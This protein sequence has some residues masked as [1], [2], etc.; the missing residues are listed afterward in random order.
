MNLLK[1]RLLFWL[2]ITMALGLC[3]WVGFELSI[4]MTY[5]AVATVCVLAAPNSGAVF[6]KSK[7]RFVGTIAGG[8][9]FV[10]MA[11]F[12]VQA[13]WLF[14][15]GL[16]LWT[17]LCYVVSVYYRFFQA[18]AAA[19]AGYTASILLGSTTDL[20]SVVV[21][22]IDRV[23]EV[24]LGVACIAVVFGIGHIRRGIVR[25]EPEL[26]AQ[27]TRILEMTESILKTPTTANQISLLRLWVSETS[28]LQLSL[29]LLAEEEADYAKQSRSIEL[30][31]LDIFTPLS[32]FAES[33]LALGQAT[34]SP[35]ISKAR[36]SV[37]DCLRF[38]S[39]NKT[40][41]AVQ[42]MIKRNVEN[43]QKPLDD[44]L[45]QIHDLHQREQVMYILV[46]LSRLL[47]ALMIY[48]KARNDVSTYPNRI[49]GQ[50]VNRKI[51]FFDA[52]GVFL[53]YLFFS[54]FWVQSQWP[55]GT[56]AIIIFASILLLQLN[57][58]RPV[59]GTIS[60]IWGFLLASFVVLIIKFTLLPLSGDFT[61]LILCTALALIPGCWFKVDSKTVAIGGGYFLFFSMLMRYSNEM[62][63]DFADFVNTALA[64]IIGLL[65]AIALMAIIHPW[66]GETRLNALCLG[67]FYD[68]EKT[69]TQ[70]L[71]GNDS[72]STLWNDRQFL[73]VRELAHIIMLR[74]PEQ[75]NHA[76][77]RFVQMS[78]LVRRFEYALKETRES[79]ASGNSSD[80]SE[81]PDL[82]S[83][84]APHNTDDLVYAFGL[85]A[86]SLAIAMTQHNQ[87]EQARTWQSLSHDLTRLN[88]NIYA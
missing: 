38:L 49:V 58:D 29:F 40:P 5:S 85:R 68:F 27:A 32:Q 64:C 57:T 74:N 2:Q 13:P 82:L 56:D 76:C 83:P 33:M 24:A 55:Y 80:S 53:G 36:E 4:D 26:K 59:L 62:S 84:I 52:V 51:V 69:L 45:L 21:I 42:D 54:W 34:D 81:W 86:K 39:T 48:R 73:R 12:F 72:A 16:A 28:K 60:M 88:K 11:T 78:E 23:S 30:A 37:L 35:E 61:W 47:T 17:A 15:I 66:R 3:L 75:A 77:K 79:I 63:Y 7:W 70:L 25:L 6:S 10:L 46:R 71:K 41:D 1:T 20:N 44:A 9:F 43:L 14:F 87:P 18:Y 22:A 31:L 67:A 50:L 8:L 19:L 65:A